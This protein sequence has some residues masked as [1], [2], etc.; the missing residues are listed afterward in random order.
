MGS[1]ADIEERLRRAEEASRACEAAL[2]R[3]QRLETVERL[4]PVLVHELKQP[5]SAVST[6]ARACLLAIEQGGDADRL[7]TA[8]EAIVAE[9][10]RAAE[11]VQGFRD[12]LGNGHGTWDVAGIDEVARDALRFASHEAQ[13]A[14]ILLRLESTT[15]LRVHIDRVQIRQVI[16]NLLWNAFEAVKARS[17]EARSVVL[18]VGRESERSVQVSVHDTGAGLATDLVP[19]LFQPFITTRATGLGMGLFICRRIIESHGGR[20]SLAANSSSGAAFAFTLPV[21]GD[22]QT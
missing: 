10:S 3:V 12:F 21:S 14:G 13:R 17:P 9:A 6:Y 2:A 7:R 22:E 1:M 15:A 5:L 4:S 16:L 20:I 8:L 19:R 18:K 11:L